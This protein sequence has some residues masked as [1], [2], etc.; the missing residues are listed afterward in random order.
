MIPHEVNI[1][2]LYIPRML[3]SVIVGLL[4]TQFTTKL[5]NY[6]KLSKYFSYTPIVYIALLLIYS[7]GVDSLFGMR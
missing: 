2:E 5:L 4:L 1:G 7:I 3:I 6:C